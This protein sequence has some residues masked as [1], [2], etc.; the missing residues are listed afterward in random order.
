MIIILGPD[1]V[2]AA[3]WPPH[4]W[5]QAGIA[6]LRSAPSRYHCWLGAWNTGG[7]LLP[8]VMP[9]ASQPVLKSVNDR[10]ASPTGKFRS[11]TKT[12]I[13]LFIWKFRVS[14]APC[15]FKCWTVSMII[16]HNSARTSIKR[17]SERLKTTYQL[18]TLDGVWNPECNQNQR[19]LQTT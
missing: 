14:K 17:D 1:L 15:K 19:F 10:W 6:E 4:C 5:I 12:K 3:S 16:E 2:F 7:S 9:A 13:M 18:S 8:K 11:E